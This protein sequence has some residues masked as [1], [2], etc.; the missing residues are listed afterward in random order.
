MA[1]DRLVFRMGKVVR[2]YRTKRIYNSGVARVQKMF[3]ANGR[4]GQGVTRGCGKTTAWFFLGMVVLVEAMAW[5]KALLS[6]DR[7]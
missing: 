6:K 1:S 2:E 3:E 7:E 5:K 4:S